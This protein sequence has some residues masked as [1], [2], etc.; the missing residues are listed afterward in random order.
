MAASSSVTS[1]G[2][3]LVVTQVIPRDGNSVPPPKHGE[4]EPPGQAPE[5]EDAEKSPVRRRGEL[6]GLGAVQVVVALLCVLFGLTGISPYLAPH[7]AFCAGVCL[8]ASGG[9][10]LAAER[11]MDTMRMRACLW[12]NAAAVPVSLVGAAYLVWL[13][14][15]V[16]PAVSVCGP[17]LREDYREAWYDCLR[18]LRPL[19]VVVEGLRGLFL[20]LLVLQAG[21]SVAT[22]I[23]ASRAIKTIP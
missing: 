17:L 22:S 11:R 1:V 6:S 20:V 19:N 7:L 2:G 9:L 18:D 12:F 14:A 13:L 23:L 21:V 10:A 5:A 8:L 4:M 15:A 3:M 16:S